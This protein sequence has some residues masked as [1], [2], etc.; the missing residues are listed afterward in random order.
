MPTG[1]TSRAER[2]RIRP[3]IEQS[4]WNVVGAAHVLR[5]ERTRPSHAN[6]ALALNRE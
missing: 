1:S 3:G 5:I 6:E 2:D 4:D